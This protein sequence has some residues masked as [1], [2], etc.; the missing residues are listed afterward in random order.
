M[1]DDPQK[2]LGPIQQRRTKNDAEHV[3]L[4]SRDLLAAIEANDVER[5]TDLA[6]VIQSVTANIETTLGRAK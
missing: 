1:S 3:Y 6:R 2:Q 4:W 5:A